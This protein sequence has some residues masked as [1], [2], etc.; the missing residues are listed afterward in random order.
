MKTPILRAIDLEKS[1]KFSQNS[2]TLKLSSGKICAT[3]VSYNASYLSSD[4]Y[5]MDSPKLV[6]YFQSL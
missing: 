1:P 3:G 4:I 2:K 6:N 5:E